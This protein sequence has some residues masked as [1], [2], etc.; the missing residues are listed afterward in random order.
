M[1]YVQQ[2]KARNMAFGRYARLR[3]LPS[4]FTSHRD[5]DT[6]GMRARLVLSA[7]SR[8]RL[9]QDGPRASEAALELR[10]LPSVESRVVVSSQISA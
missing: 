1:K 3:N 4:R 10:D 7:F 2:S 6:S 8:V 9:A 5:I